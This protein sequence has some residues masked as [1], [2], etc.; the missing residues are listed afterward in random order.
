M[1]MN[2]GHAHRFDY[3]S[4]LNITRCLYSVYLYPTTECSRASTLL[5]RG[6]Q[7]KIGGR[8]SFLET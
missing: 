3:I 5:H 2:Y 8:T 1:V 4:I 6:S 7:E